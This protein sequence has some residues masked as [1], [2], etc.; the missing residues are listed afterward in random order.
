MTGPA[1]ALALLSTSLPGFAP[2]PVSDVRVP[3][4]VAVEMSQGRVRAQ[5]TTSVDLMPLLERHLTTTDAYSGAG[6]I[7]YVAGT[8]DVNGDGF[9]AVTPQGKTTTFVKIERRM[10]GSWSDGVHSY[11]VSLNVSIFRARLDN[12][13]EIRDQDTGNMVWAK[14][15]N[16]LFR[17]AY[18]AGEPVVIAG[19]PYR[20]FFS[21]SPSYGLCF[22][23]DDTSNGGHDW[24]FYMVPMSQVVGNASS[25]R[26]YGGDA[27]RLR[28]T[29]DLKTLE[30]SR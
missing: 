7:T 19:R 3:V 16:D 27:V 30:I 29:P 4:P 13:I 11:R 17:A 18:K 6:G 26:M 23:Y 24:K 21:Q 10:G 14:R 9:L 12:I 15:I 1:A 20:L 2:A 22:I 8:L 25:Y 28:V 5:D